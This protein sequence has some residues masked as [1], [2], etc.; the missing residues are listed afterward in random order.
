[1]TFSDLEIEYLGAQLLGRL[2]TVDA[3]GAPQNS[4]VAF[5]HNPET[6]TI[7]I[8]G[9][10]LV[11]SRKFRN[12]QARPQV[13]FVVDDLPST[14]PWRARGIEI[15]GEAEALTGDEP[16][17]RIRPRRIIAWGIDPDRPHHRRN[18]EP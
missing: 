6:G 9:H 11:A 8:G 14:R 17:I 7:D 4:P 15:R 13:S 5:R 3:A 1:M 10:N 12:V 2:A 16:L 18:V